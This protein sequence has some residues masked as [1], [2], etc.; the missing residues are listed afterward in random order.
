MFLISLSKY[1]NNFYGEIQMS[2]LTKQDRTGHPYFT[3]EQSNNVKG[4][5]AIPEAWHHR[6]GDIILCDDV[7][8]NC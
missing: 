6:G 1:I 8:R 3:Q 2:M 5:D 4:Y 7:K